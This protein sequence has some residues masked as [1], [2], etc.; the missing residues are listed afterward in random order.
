V[1]VDYLLHSDGAPQREYAKQAAA[2]GVITYSYSTDNF[3]W[4]EPESS[5]RWTN[6]TV[7]KNPVAADAQQS[8]WID[9]IFGFIDSITGVLFQKVEGQRGEYHFNFVDDNESN[10]SLA[11]INGYS[12][13][14]YR[15]NKAQYGGR[16]D[17][18]SLCQAILPS[19]GITG[20]NGTSSNPSFTTDNTILS[21]NDRGRTFF[22]TEDDQLALQDVLGLDANPKP[23]ESTHV[24]RG[25]ED[26]MLG[27]SGVRDTFRLTAKGVISEEPYLI[28]DGPKEFVGMSNNYNIPYIA[29]FNGAEGDKILISKRLFNTKTPIDG[30]VPNRTPAP[31]GL[32]IM[33]RNY[34]GPKL[35]YNTK[36]N[37]YYNGAGKLNLDVDGKTPGPGPSKYTDWNAYMLAFVDPVGPS[38]LPFQ[39]NWL[40]LF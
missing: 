39:S 6:E 14:Y 2:D 35:E 34:Y 17:I 26:L 29:N 1:S 38:S 24:Q 40:G 9:T 21:F 13:A 27:A 33:F 36:H 8:L 7:T 3:K 16:D 15:H 20:P 11:F 30:N 12:Q 23:L 10:D 18:R 19:L 37:V 4:I 22:L 32:K 25:K 31:K 28:K 5:I